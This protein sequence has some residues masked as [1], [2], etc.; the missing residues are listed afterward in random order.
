MSQENRWTARILITAVMIV[1]GC[2]AWEQAQSHDLAQEDCIFYATAA[3]K[4]A[5]ARNKG[6]SP[7]ETVP[8]VLHLITSCYER[9]DVCP[10]KDG[11][12]SKRLM[13]FVRDVYTLE[14]KEK[15]A[16]HALIDIEAVQNS[17]YQ[18]CVDSVNRKQA[19]PEAPTPMKPDQS[20]PF[21]GK[22]VES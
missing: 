19:K 10:I 1:G 12:D 18:Q 7:V 3:K 14:N 20:V 9:G 15:D 17:I 13:D 8:H 2:V 11:Q 16:E 22:Q 5:D 21:K 6:E 4:I